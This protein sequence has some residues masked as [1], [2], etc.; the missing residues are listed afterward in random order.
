MTI[1]VGGGVLGKRLFK[2]A[3]NGKTVPVIAMMQ[4]KKNNQ[5]GPTV[6]KVV[7]MRKI[8]PPQPMI[9]RNMAV[10]RK[11]ATRGDEFVLICR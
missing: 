11:L 1:V 2:N 8:K 6:G 3:T 10:G 4:K 9:K 5:R 7:T